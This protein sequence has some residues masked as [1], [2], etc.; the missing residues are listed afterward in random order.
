MEAVLGQPP[1][2]MGQVVFFRPSSFVGVALSFPPREG[3]TAYGSLANGR[4]FILNVTPGEHDFTVRSEVVNHLH[5]EAEAG[6]TQYVSLSLSMGL[7]AAHPNLNPSTSTA[8]QAA[9][10][11]M[12][13]GPDH[14]NAAPATH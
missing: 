12:R 6:E 11:H 4:Y 3:E 1:A 8:F 14:E 10:P 2:G 13:R 9:L 7:L 5:L